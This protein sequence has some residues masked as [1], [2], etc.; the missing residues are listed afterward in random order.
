MINGECQWEWLFSGELAVFF[1]GD[2]GAFVDVVSE[3]DAV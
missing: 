2:E 1:G 3:E